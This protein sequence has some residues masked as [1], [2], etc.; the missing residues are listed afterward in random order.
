MARRA[1]ELGARAREL[2]FH[3][4][5]MVHEAQSGHISP[6][7]GAADIVTTLFFE[8]M[9]VDPDLPEMPDRDRFVLSKG[10]SCPVLYAVLAMRGFFPIE[11]L[12]T[13]RQL[14]S[15]RRHRQ[16]TVTRPTPT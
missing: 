13:L 11:E 5:D 15:R 1:V 12:K 14:G 4:V 3:I 10:H 9:R 16:I 2:R 7:L 6:G 8:T